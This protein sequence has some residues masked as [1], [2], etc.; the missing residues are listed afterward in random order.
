[1]NRQLESK[2]KSIEYHL[3]TAKDGANNSA[4]VVHHATSDVLNM[5][6][7]YLL[8]LVRAQD[9]ELEEKA[10]TDTGKNKRFSTAELLAEL[11]WLRWLRQVSWRY[12]DVGGPSKEDNERLATLKRFAHLPHYDEIGMNDE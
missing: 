12:S 8:E 6:V 2:L 5:D 9:K 11:W 1:M 3:E 7:P 10:N 4:L